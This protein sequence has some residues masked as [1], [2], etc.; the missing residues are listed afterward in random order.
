MSELQSLAEKV[1][2]GEISHCPHGRP[3]A[4]EVTKKMLDKGL[5][6]I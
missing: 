1:F 4:F 2:S 3:I 5:G 6:R